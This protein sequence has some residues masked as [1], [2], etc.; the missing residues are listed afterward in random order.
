MSIYL[1]PRQVTGEDCVQCPYCDAV[2]EVDDGRWR[3]E[4]DGWTELAI[5]CKVCDK[6]FVLTVK[7]I[8][9]VSARTLALPNNRKE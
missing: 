7:Y 3:D 2:F 1:I 4:R 5:P 9:Q 6:E 8:M